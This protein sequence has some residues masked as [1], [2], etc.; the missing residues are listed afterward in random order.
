[1]RT[2]S[3]LPK[4]FTFSLIFW[5]YYPQGALMFTNLLS[6]GYTLRQGGRL[7]SRGRSLTNNVTGPSG[8]TVE[9]PYVYRLCR[10]THFKSYEVRFKNLAILT[11]GKEW[12]C[13]ALGQAQMFAADDAGSNGSL[14]VPAAPTAPS[15]PPTEKAVSAILP[16]VLVNS[17]VTLS[18]STPT[19]TLHFHPETLTLPTS[20]ECS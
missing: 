3:S 8:Q 6:P 9:V 20:V 2:Y 1:M 16:Q 18:T 19:R 13:S 4:S 5:D 11:G 12:V 7:W 10:Q 17:L 15:P 14:A